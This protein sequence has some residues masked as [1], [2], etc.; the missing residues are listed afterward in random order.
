MCSSDLGG[1]EPDPEGNGA[2]AGQFRGRGLLFGLDIP[3]PQGLI[4]QL[5]DHH[6]DI[7]RGEHEVRGGDVLTVLAAR[8]DRDVDRGG[9][10]RG[11]RA[12]Q[13]PV[14][15]EDRLH[16]AAEVSPVCPAPLFSPLG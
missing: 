8:E 13:P 11:K 16:I 9:V 12:L 7:P 6:V 10:G 14:S 5:L 4:L 1:N 3:E 15:Q 2:T